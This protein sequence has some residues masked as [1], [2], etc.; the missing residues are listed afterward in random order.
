MKELNTDRTILRQ[1]HPSDVN[2]LYEFCSLVEPAEMIGRKP[3][4]DYSYTTRYIEHEIRKEETYAIVLKLTS[5][6]IG[7]ISMRKIM[8][9]QNI[10]TRML[11]IIINPLYWRKGYATEVIK[12]VIRYAFEEINV[13]KLTV[14]HY[15]FNKSSAAVINKL[16]FTFERRLEKVYSY[17]NQL[18][19]AVEYAIYR[20]DYL[21]KKS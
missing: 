6:L 18:V 17:Q 15:A 2:D 19:D 8:T 20:K 10:T 5:K 7:T 12:E 13:D 16:G 11:N 9:E 14:G 3:H 21:R 4:V 1:L